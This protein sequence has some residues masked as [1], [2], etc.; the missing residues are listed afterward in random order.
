MGR[1]WKG[2]ARVGVGRGNF[3]VGKGL[4]G[5]KLRLGWSGDGREKIRV[6][7]AHAT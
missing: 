5:L 1:A 7:E 4:A 2:Y 6:G 3:R